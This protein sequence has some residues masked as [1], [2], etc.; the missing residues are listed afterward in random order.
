MIDASGSSAST[1]VQILR[2]A[3]GQT[4]D[5]I[6]FKDPTA[7]SNLVWVDSKGRIGQHL[8]GDFSIGSTALGY[9]AMSNMSGNVATLNTAIGYEALKGGGTNLLV[10]TRNVVIGTS[11]G[12]GITTGSSNVLLGYAVGNTITTGGQNIFIGYADARGNTNSVIAIGQYSLNNNT[13]DS[14]I[15]IGVYSTHTNVSGVDNT[16]IGTDAARSCGTYILSNTY[17]GRTVGYFNSGSYNT[18]I[19]SKALG[20]NIGSAANSNQNTAIGYQ[21][22]AAETSGNYN[23]AIGYNTLNT[24]VSGLY[25][26]AIGWSA[27]T[28]VNN[29][30]GCIIIGAS[31]TANQNNQLVIGSTTVKVGKSDGTGEQSVSLTAPSGVSRLLEARINGTI[32]NIPLLP[33]GTTQ[34]ASTVVLPP[35]ITSTGGITLDN[36]YNGYIIEQTGVVS[37]GTFTIGSPTIPGWNCMIVNIGSGV[38]VASGSNTMR[39]PGGL[40]KSRTQYSSISIYRRGDGSFILGG[41]LA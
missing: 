29:I 8:L 19:G 22:M 2:S 36:T 16:V 3:S 28:S 35:I 9:N 14:N 12:A 39:S 26:T 30:S 11:A 23:T 13:S 17:I 38:I 18:A 25:N 27:T 6:Q 7:A 24:V 32:Y 15:S 40:N 41:D 10:G 21:S 5:F 33:S 34:L 37:S 31:A 4:A 1:V 20:G